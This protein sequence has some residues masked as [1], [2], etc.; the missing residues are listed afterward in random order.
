MRPADNPFASSR[1]DGL[2]YRFGHG[3]LTMIVERLARH[4]GRGAVVGPHG[5]GKTTLLDT[6]A[7]RLAGEPV[8]V[9][10]DAAT[11]HAL[12]TA[13]A[14]LPTPVEAHHTLLIDGAERLGPIDWWRLLRR[15]RHAGAVV[16]T[17]HRTG[18]LPT[19]H[20]CVTTPELLR[21]LVR[22]LDPATA[23]SVDIGDLFRRHRG[24]IRSCFR[25]LY[26]RCSNRP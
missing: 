13:V 12:R 2:A 5:S 18:R 8:R 26:D 19:I 4:G 21:R 10:L 17:S 11:R 22:E 16:T 20:T 25:E 3:D 9:R 23:A 14:A 15:I 24:D 1:I 7:S 6:L